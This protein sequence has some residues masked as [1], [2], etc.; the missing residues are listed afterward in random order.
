MLRRAAF[1]AYDRDQIRQTVAAALDAPRLH[2]DER[3]AVSNELFYCPGSA[4]QRA[5]Q[6]IYDLLE[7]PL[8]AE[9]GVS[10]IRRSAP[11]IASLARSLQS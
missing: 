3:Y 1:V 6:C 8:P 11:S 2:H 5:V 10:A 7:C 4:T 9:A